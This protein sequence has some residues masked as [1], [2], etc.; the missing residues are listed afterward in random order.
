M[1]KFYK[2]LAAGVAAMAVTAAASAAPA[3]LPVSS[4]APSVREDFNSMWDSQASEALLLL[5][6]GWA[7][8]RNLTAPRT[9]GAWADASTEVMYAGGVSLA[10]NAKNGTWNFG[11]SADPTDRAIG[12]LSTTVSGGTRC[13]SL[14]T[15][16]HNADSRSIDRI[17]VGYDIEKYRNGANTAGFDVQ[18]YYSYDGSTWLSAGDDFLTH[19]APDGETLGSEIVPISTVVSEPKT[20][21]VDV[22]AGGHIYLAWNVSVSSGSTPDKAQG[23]AIDNID[24]TASFSSGDTHYVYV[25]NAVKA[26]ALTIYS[27]DNA[28]YGPRPGMAST[29]SKSVNGVAY[30]A[31]PLEGTDTF[32]MYVCAG[33]DEF[34][35]VTVTPGADCYYC[36]S[37]SGIEEIADPE[38]YTGWVDPSRPPF[39]SSG[40]YVR[41]EVNSWGASADWEFSDEGNGT[42]VIY[43]KVLSGA[44]KISD[45]NWSSSCNYG[46]NGTN[47]MIDT[48]YPLTAATDN[49]ISCGAYVFTCKRIVLSITDSGASLLLE[50]DD[51]DSGLTTVYMIGDFN[52]WNYMDPTGALQLD[53]SDNLFKGRV[54]LR[55]GDSGASQWL[56]YQRLGKSGAWGAAAES[57]QLSLSGSLVKG[58][59][60][61]VMTAPATYDV[62]FSLESG[63]YTLTKVASE[64]V[65][66]ALNP[67]STVLVPENP[68]SVKVLSL[69]NSLIYY[70]DQD[71]VFNDIAAAM[72]RDAVWTKHTLLGKPLS[73]HWDEGDGLAPDGTPGAKMMVRSE[74]WSHIILQEQSSLP[75]TSPEAFRTNVH[76]WVEYIREY[77]PN[78][79]AVVILPVNWAYSGDWD[80]FSAYNKIFLDNYAS[81]AA[82]MGVILCPV[83]SAYDNVYRTEGAE[84]TLDWY[85]DD[86]HPS[87]QSTYMAACMEFGLIYGTDPAEITYTPAGLEESTA[88]DMRAYA[89]QA[90]AGHTNAIDHQ[91]ATVAFSAKVFDAFGLEVEDA[92][93]VSFAVSGGG[94]ISPEGLFTS[95]GTRGIFSVTAKSGPFEKTASI[96]VA[97]AET[98]VITYPAIN[99]NKDNPVASEDFNTMGTEA[100][101]TLPE[102]WRIDKQTVGTRAIGTYALASEKTTYA[103][104]TSLPSNA[105]NG[106][107][108]F[109]ADG[110]DDRAP[111]GITTGVANGTRAVNLYTHLY[112]DGKK[113][114]DRLD[115][116]YN[117]EKYRKGN[118]AAGF[119]VQMYY[120]FD[121][122]NW[123]SAGEGFRTDFAPDSET[124]GYAEVP[125]ETV[126]VDATLPVNFGPGLDLYLAWNISVTSGDAAQGAM[127]LAIDDFT[128]EAIEP[129]VPETLHRIYVDN[130]TSWDALGLYAWGDGEIYGVWPGAAPIDEQLINGTLW[131]VF[132]LDAASG[133]YNLIFNNWNNGKQLPD[134][135]ISDMRDYYLKIDDEAVTE[136]S[137]ETGVDTIVIN[138]ISFD[139]R[140]VSCPGAEAIRILN[141]Q[142]VQVA[143]AGDAVDTI[144]LAQGIYIISA[145]TP[146]GRTV[147]KIAVR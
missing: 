27:P 20:L 8:D 105:K 126:A 103:G 59:T 107:W 21:M 56:I 37:P 94:T 18:L 130:R 66:L 88:A 22:A 2:P 1:N 54:S 9:V 92:E 71:K 50:S 52:G 25:E 144:G 72:G 53:E 29:M 14:M 75:R 127:A 10:S 128:V 47:V 44:F 113:A 137:I 110:S 129:E 104:G 135:T 116:T 82:E 81:V 61:T 83:A 19:F 31:W 34:G 119:T 136:V 7:V 60:Y 62:T 63:D 68:A 93:P 3:S 141:L 32:S 101:A 95:D 118:N 77:C 40:I 85:L 43:D 132:G 74:A 96:K 131:Q 57:A 65:E 73:T 46:S 147:K 134:F 109:G 80:N 123:T 117:V 41:G 138:D 133:T 79:N 142:G 33:S 106:V 90:L 15:S 5:P 48:P 86:R 145:S 39:K 4:A 12:G 24:I 111:G 143:T 36:A 64:A 13:W 97:D 69:N 30:R 78:P 28:A 6:E 89:S 42:Y 49:N 114:F 115:I 87:L 70:N 58:N 55:A 121:G 120:S 51:D 45:A 108:N 67:L 91:K 146:N 11:S 23:L 102:G 122:R 98:V 112:N 76:R 16:I 125:G 139:G 26:S 124:A 38:S 17:S 35:P 140:T 99:I 84:A 100:E